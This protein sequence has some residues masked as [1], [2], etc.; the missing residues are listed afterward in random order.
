MPHLEVS[1]YKSSKHDLYSHAG[2]I[3]IVDWACGQWVYF[4]IEDGFDNF[5]SWDELGQKVG[6][7]FKP[8]KE[9]TYYPWYYQAKIVG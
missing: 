8:R 7:L 3:W 1:C 6:V 2:K 5:T 4:N 9:S